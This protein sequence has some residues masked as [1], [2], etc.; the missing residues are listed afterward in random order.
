MFPKIQ[1]LYEYIEIW[2]NIGICNEHMKK[3]IQSECTDFRNIFATPSHYLNPHSF[4][5]VSFDNKFGNI[6]FMS[7]H[8]REKYELITRVS[9]KTVRPNE[10]K[11]RCDPF[12][13]DWNNSSTL[14]TLTGNWSYCN[15]VKPS[16]PLL[17][18]AMAH[19]E[20]S[21][22]EWLNQCIESTGNWGCSAIL[23]EAATRCQSKWVVSLTWWHHIYSSVLLWISR[24]NVILICINEHLRDDV[25]ELLPSNTFGDVWHNALCYIVNWLF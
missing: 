8:Q 16:A 18:P 11:N 12:Q 25:I 1:C 22:I 9:V 3:R 2:N 21:V 20:D 24:I 15:G 23:E 14:L 17:L 5:P 4:R 7:W 19:K 13:S 6:S 10:H